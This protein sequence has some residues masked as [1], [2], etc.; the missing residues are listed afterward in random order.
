MAAGY[1]AGTPTA[2]SE[3]TFTLQVESAYA[4]KLVDGVATPVS[5]DVSASDPNYVPKACIEAKKGSANFI[6]RLNFTKYS[7]GEV[8]TDGLIYVTEGQTLKYYIDIRNDGGIGTEGMVVEDKLPSEAG[9]A[10]SYVDGSAKF[11]GAPLE[12]TLIDDAPGGAR[13]IE[14]N[15]VLDVPPG[16][17]GT[18]EYELRVS[19]FEY[20]RYC[21]QVIGS[22][23]QENV[24]YG[25]RRV[26]VKMNPDIRIDKTILSIEAPATGT[27]A[28]DGKSATVE[29]FPGARIQFQ[30]TL[31]NNTSE[32]RKVG[33][34]DDLGLLI[35]PRFISGN[36]T[37]ASKWQALDGDFLEYP[38]NE[39]GGLMLGAGQTRTAVISARLP[40]ECKTREYINEA[41]FTI[42]TNDGSSEL[43]VR[44]IPPMQVKIKHNCGNNIIEYGIK[45]DKSGSPRT[46]SL[47]DEFIYDFR[48][49][50]ANDNPESPAIQPVTGTVILPPDF[51]YVRMDGGSI[52]SSAPIIDTTREDRR[53]VLTWVIP[54]LNNRQEGK[55][56]F[57]ARSGDVVASSVAWAIAD[58]P[59][60]LRRDCKTD[61]GPCQT[62]DEGGLQ[63]QYA[64]DT[65]A[66]RPLITIEP[67]VSDESCGTPGDAR[68]YSLKLIN[69]NDKAYSSTTVTVT[70]PIGLRYRSPS[71]GTATPRIEYNLDTAQ[72]ILT[73]ENLTIAARPSSTGFTQVP[74]EVLLEVGQVYDKLET[75]VEVTSPGG[76]IPLKDGFRDPIIDG[77]CLAQPSLAKEAMPRL[78]RANEE[79]LYAITVAT[80]L[81]A[82]GRWRSRMFCRNRYRL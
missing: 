42:V 60:L 76:L 71:A 33:I 19:G 66:V 53:Q 21:N 44:R 65:L 40:E 62:V 49:K 70:L 8:A 67:S 45:A 68:I 39:G 79:F 31:T 26:C 80:R 69:T 74:L 18:L 4:K 16:T 29:Q 20:T 73:W 32:A 24:A 3:A 38:I 63:V 50:N 48:I 27:V 52:V 11:N 9:A 81:K 41:L 13:V 5:P 22:R 34:Y 46:V 14:W 78:M 23:E 51:S 35:E 28:G 56:R 12:P 64:T 82:S 15:D 10:F 6:P 59:N 1:A 17:T 2:P 25:N 75:R 72:Q 54:T 58:A 55:I 37:D 47:R 77:V 43:V 30:L 7:D 36:G 57:V 61:G